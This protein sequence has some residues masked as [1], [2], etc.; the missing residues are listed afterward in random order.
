MAILS[1][2]SK[3]WRFIPGVFERIKLE[4]GLENGGHEWRRPFCVGV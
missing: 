4:V 3:K 2:L 1:S